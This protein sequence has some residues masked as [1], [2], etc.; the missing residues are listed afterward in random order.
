MRIIRLSA[1]TAMATSP[2]WASS[3]RA[4]A[5]AD[6][7]PARDLY[8]TRGHSLLLDGVLIPAEYLINDCSVLWD[9]TAR[10]VE[11]FHLELEH[12][13]VLLAEGAEAESYREDGNRH[14]FHNT[15]APVHAQLSMV[16]YAP[17]LTGDPEVDRVW[18]R[19]LARAVPAKVALTEDADLHLLADG[20]R[21]AGVAEDPMRHRVRL[22]RVPVELGIA[23]RMCNPVRLDTARDPRN[24]GVALRRLALR[25]EGAELVLGW[26]SSWLQEGFNG[27]EPEAQSRWTTGDALVPAR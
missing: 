4:G 22:D 23:S 25:S 1:A 27:P 24:L 21:V 14:L 26:A 12:H 8:P 13:D 9:E 5:L 18:A 6:G 17:V 15:D 16:P 10:M 2:C 20:V 19:L 7:V 3:V 11:F